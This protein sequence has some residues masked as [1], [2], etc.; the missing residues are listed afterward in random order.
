MDPAPATFSPGPSKRTVRTAKGQ[1]LDVPEEWFLL[2]PGDAALT[3]RVKAAGEFWPVAEKRGRRIFSNGV[4]APQATIERIRAELEVE[5]STEQYAKRKEAGARRRD[6]AQAEYVEDFFGAVV[7]FL[8]FHPQHSSLA[9]RKRARLP[10]L[11]STAR[12]IFG[13]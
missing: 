6:A 10:L 12:G 11:I 8:A 13:V 3:R 2:E 7:S 9:E 4:W 5:Q 1:I